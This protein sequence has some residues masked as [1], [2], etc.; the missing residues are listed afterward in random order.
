MKDPA[1]TPGQYDKLKPPSETEAGSA[2][3]QLVE[4]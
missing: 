2:G 4:G 3:K 1:T